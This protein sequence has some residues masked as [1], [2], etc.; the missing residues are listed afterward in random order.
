MNQYHNMDIINELTD[1]T[2]E[3][4]TGLFEGLGV[5]CRKQGRRYVGI[6]PCHDSDNEGAWNFYPD[7]DTVRGIWQCHT[8]N[9]HQTYNKSLVGLIRG[10]LTFRGEECSYYTAVDYLLKYNNTD[11]IKKYNF[12]IHEIFK[13][14]IKGLISLVT[15][16]TFKEP[17]SSLILGK[18][19][20]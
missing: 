16:S 6:C 10:I 12:T 5:E 3:N 13:L 8:R 9:C 17:G 11:N 1:M 15:S 18:K 19:R 7:G 4:I 20:R 14:S 2:C